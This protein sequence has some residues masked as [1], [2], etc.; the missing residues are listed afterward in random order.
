[1]MIPTII[2]IKAVIEVEINLEAV[3]IIDTAKVLVNIK[4]MTMYA[5]NVATVVIKLTNVEQQP[6]DTDY[7]SSFN[8]KMVLQ[9]NIT[10]AIEISYIIYVN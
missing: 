10:Q 3:M 6:Q 8:T 2:M 4:G 7:D 1:M 9:T 5:I